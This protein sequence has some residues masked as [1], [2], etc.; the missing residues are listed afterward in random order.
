MTT[1]KSK[2][3]PYT[4]NKDASA[5]G[6]A[7]PGAK[8]LL[9]I[10]SNKW[11]FT[12]LGIYAYRPMR[13][14]TMLSVHGTGRAFDAGYKQSNQKLVTEI[15]DWLADN[16]VA[17]GIEEIHQYVWG[18]HGRGFRCNRDGKPGWKEWDA[19]NNGGPGGYWIHVEVSPTF[20]QSGNMIVGAW[21]KII[22]TFVT[23]IV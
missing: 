5:T 14:S 6:S 18:T 8:K 12:N 13:G 22:H 9:E 23:P 4:G 15:C 19:E 11:G 2:V 10:L 17:L 21:K 16:H 7:T 20:A 3:M 1:P